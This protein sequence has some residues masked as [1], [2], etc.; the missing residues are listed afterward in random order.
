MDQIWAPLNNLGGIEFILAI[1]KAFG[2]Q[3]CLHFP[4]NSLDFIDH[5]DNKDRRPTLSK[6]K[7]LLE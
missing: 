5:N 6:T 7:C 4:R 2:I 3:V 1:R